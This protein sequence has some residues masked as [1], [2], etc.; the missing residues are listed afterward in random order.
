MTQLSN[1]QFDRVARWLDGEDIQL[2][3]RERELADGFIKIFWR[4]ELQ[5]I[6]RYI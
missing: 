3:E 4:D 1:E 2:V 6:S 5:R